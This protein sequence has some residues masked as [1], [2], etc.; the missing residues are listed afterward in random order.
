MAGHSSMVGVRRFALF[1]AYFAMGSCADGDG[2]KSARE[3]A[4]SIASS[5]A[6][7]LSAPPECAGFPANRI[8]LG[9]DGDDVL[10]GSNKAECLVGFGG[11]DIIRAGGGDDVIVAGDGDDR[12]YGENGSDTIYLG[13]GN[14][15]AWGGNQADAI[16]GEDGD[17]ELYGENQDD[18]L[19]GGPGRDSLDG[20]NGK[21]TVY[22]GAGDDHIVSKNGKDQVFGGDG[23]D[24][25][26]TNNAP[27][28]VSGEG[29]H[30]VIV[31]GHAPDVVSGGDGF[32]ACD[33]ISCETPEGSQTGCEANEDCDDGYRC[34]VSNG[35]CVPASEPRCED[36]ALPNPHDDAGV[37]LD[38]GECIPSDTVDL[39]CDGLDDDC[40]GDVDDDYVP[41]QTSCGVGSCGASG[42]TSCV[43]GEEVDSCAA[44][45]LSRLGR[46]DPGPVRQN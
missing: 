42:T 5:R 9:T 3:Q 7:L 37:D 43:A 38:A 31:G 33:G 45:E 13:A 35:L 30:D 16:F 36:G 28:L 11:N 21:D 2:D 8:I 19:Q 25:I 44:S 10:N 40:D 12:V 24:L 6:A 34:V 41:A 29:C 46:A 39:T 1:C 26:E 22:G 32:D 18:L 17:D 4:P 14:D 20:D 15:K 23:A 27:D